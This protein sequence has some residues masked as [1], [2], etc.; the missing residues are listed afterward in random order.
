MPEQGR[1]AVG[2]VPTKETRRLALAAFNTVE[3]HWEAGLQWQL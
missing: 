2:S 1:G 3:A